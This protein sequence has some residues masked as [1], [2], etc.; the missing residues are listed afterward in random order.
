MVKQLPDRCERSGNCLTAISG[1]AIVMEVRQLPD[2]HQESGNCLP[3]PRASHLE[4]DVVHHG[5]NEGLIKFL[6]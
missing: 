5:T 6:R 3:A 1:E 4:S 2:R